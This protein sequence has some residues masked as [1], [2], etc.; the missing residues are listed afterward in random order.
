MTAFFRLVLIFTFVIAAWPGNAQTNLPGTQSI[1]GVLAELVQTPAVSGYEQTVGKIISAR[2]QAMPRHYNPKTDNLGNVTVTLGSGSPTRLLVA[3]IDEPGF[4]VSGITPEGYLTLQRLPQGGNLPLFNELY[5]AQPVKLQTPKGAWIN[6]AMSGVSIHLQPQRQHPPSMAD[7][8]NMYV[9]VGATSAEQA[10]A[11]GADV[12]SPLAIDRHFYWLDL[13]KKYASP[14]IGDRFGAAAL[15]ELLRS[16]DAG[17]LKG[18]LTVAF[19]TQQWLGARGLQKLLYQ[20][21]PDE[22]I[23]VGRLMRPAAPA[24][25]AGQGGSRRPAA[26][27]EAQRE[28]APGF[29]QLPGSGVIIASEKPEAELS[30]I[31]AELKQAA[32][33][34]NAAINT[35]IT[36]PLLPRGGY[37][38]QAK[39]PERT[40]YLSIAT[41]FPSTPAEVIDAGDLNA[42]TAVLEQYLAGSAQKPLA[43]TGAYAEPGAPDRPA[44]APATEAVLKKLIETYGVSGGH[45]QNMR[46]TVAA[47]LPAWAKP[48]TDDAGNLI[49]HWNGSSGNTGGKPADAKGPSTK[50]PSIAVV[51]HMDEIGYEVHAI[52]PDG[53][54]ELE[55]KGGGV[56]AYFLGHVAMVHSG[57]RIWPGV[58]E[59]PEG[60]EKSDFQW[61][62]NPRQ[63]FHMDIGA[64]SPE[65]VAAMHIKTGDFVTVPKQY[66]KLMGRRASAR[67]FDDRVGCT[68]LVAAAWALGPDLKGRDVTFIWSTSEEIGLE[69]AAAAAKHLAAEG[70]TPDY[71]FAIDTF[72]SSDSPLESKR[73]GD[74]LLGQGFVVRA[75]DNSNVVPRSLVER[76]VSMARGGGIPAQYGITGGGNDGAAFLLYGATDI[77][78]G[79][80]LRYSHSPAEVVDVRDVEA[81]SRI[82]T[83]IAQGW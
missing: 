68:A 37:M 83:A 11:G 10:R 31:A 30:G 24:A 15:L 5:A 65:D 12:L 23:Y 48:E 60:W 57:E 35:D 4:V 7:L 3:P 78:L 36:A 33:Q 67:A 64:H 42:L 43:E 28:S 25:G 39:L 69:G 55:P 50:S 81:L 54:L 71:V 2:L 80:P 53:R 63:M 9:D 61:P 34:V 26:E 45:E 52:L 79:W 56:L 18:T 40:V 58:L 73:F 46:E 8:D 27:I 41:G 75:V 29:K 38:A 32:S 13:G 77:A 47:L 22:M 19:V 66:H 14:A 20:L 62:R 51:A 1:S 21:K 59:L 76:M 74:G 82:I 16:L 17:K 70:K 44:S 6:G 72:V 49:L